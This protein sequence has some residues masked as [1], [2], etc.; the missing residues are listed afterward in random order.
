MNA[1]ISA[2]KMTNTSVIAAHRRSFRL[3]N[4]DTAGSR[5]NARK[6]ATPISTNIDDIDA[7]TRTVA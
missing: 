2:T 4:H 5:P 1:P 6:N 7:N 3:T